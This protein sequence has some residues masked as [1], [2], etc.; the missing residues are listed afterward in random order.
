MVPIRWP[1]GPR[2][3]G[4]RCRR[5]CR[6]GSSVVRKPAALGGAVRTRP[7][8][9]APMAAPGTF[10]VAV[11]LFLCGSCPYPAAAHSHPGKGAH[12]KATG[13][14]CSWGW[15]MELPVMAGEDRMWGCVGWRAVVAHTGDPATPDVSQDLWNIYGPLQWDCQEDQA[16]PGSPVGGCLWAH[17]SAGVFVIPPAPWLLVLQH[18][19]PISLV[20]DPIGLCYMWVLARMI[21]GSAPAALSFLVTSVVLCTGRGQDTEAFLSTGTLIPATVF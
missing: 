7:W 5:C 16:I 19:C 2:R 18:S 14:F 15:G 10:L 6:A 20:A 12:G 3:E 8:S 21:S 13:P 17:Y 11:L 1:M 9:A 4:P